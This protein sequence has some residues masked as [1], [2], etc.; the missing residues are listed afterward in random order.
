MQFLW[1]VVVVSAM[2]LV[3]AI[4]NEVGPVASVNCSTPFQIIS[5][6]SN[7]LATYIRCRFYIPRQETCPRHQV[8][9]LRAKR[10]V[11]PSS[12][13]RLCNPTYKFYP[14]MP[15]SVIGRSPGYSGDNS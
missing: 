7:N 3:G 4:F 14:P 13:V 8:L 2:P 11:Y 9:S 10:C 1:V 5:R 6:E 12:L 15:N